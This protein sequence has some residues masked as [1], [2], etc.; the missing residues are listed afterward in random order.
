M[1]VLDNTLL[2]HLNEPLPPPHRQASR[3]YRRTPRANRP[4]AGHSDLR[5]HETSF[6]LGILLLGRVANLRGGRETGVSF[7]AATY[8]FV[9]T[10][11]IV[12]GG[13]LIPPRISGGHPSPVAPLPPPPPVTEAVTYWLLLKV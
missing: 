9:G 7:M 4:S 1:E 12:I 11:F 6:C 10:L 8:L 3:Q 5:P 2:L 13:G